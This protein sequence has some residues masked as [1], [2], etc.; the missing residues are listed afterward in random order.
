MVRGSKHSEVARA[1]QRLNRRAGPGSGWPKG[2]PQPE[3]KRARQA[4]FMK[5][6]WQEPAYRDRMIVNIRNVAITYRDASRKYPKG[7]P[8]AARRHGL[9]T[10]QYDGLV[11]NGCQVCGTRPA[12]V[13]HDHRTGIVRGALCGHCNRAL[14]LLQEDASRLLKLADYLAQLNPL[15]EVTSG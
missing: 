2:V 5:R 9:T 10:E 13:D 8:R 7:T 3:A 11:A 15:K 14:G 12:Q 1:K 6:K 4:A